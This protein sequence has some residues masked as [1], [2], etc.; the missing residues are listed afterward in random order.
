MPFS[1]PA[2]AYHPQGKPSSLHYD[3]VTCG[4]GWQV[5]AEKKFERQK[6][7]TGIIRMQFSCK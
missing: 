3:S 2:V 4:L 1:V 7:A 5:Q 6:Y